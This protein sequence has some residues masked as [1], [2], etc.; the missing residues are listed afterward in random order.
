VGPEPTRNRTAAAHPVA[1]LIFG[2]GGSTVD[3]STVGE[4]SCMG[5]VLCAN[6]RHVFRMVEYRRKLL[7]GEREG[8]SAVAGACAFLH[9]PHREV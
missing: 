7:K 6:E 9:A 8:G 5:S 1:D 2:M 3:G 4:S